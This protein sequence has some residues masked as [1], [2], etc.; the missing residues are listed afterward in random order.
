MLKELLISL[1]LCAASALHAANYLTFT[2]E[3]DDS[4]FGIETTSYGDDPDIEIQYSLDGG[5]TWAALPTGTLISLNYKGDKALLKGKK[6]QAYTQGEDNYT[7]FVMTGRIAAS[8]SV[9]SL[10]DGN[11]KNLT[12]K[13]EKC[14]YRLFIDCTSLTKAPELPATQLNNSCY[15]E[16]FRGCSRLKQAPKLPAK[17]LAKNCY[18]G[19]FWKCTSLTQAPEL[20]ATK[21]EQGCYNSMFAKCTSLTHTPHLPA[22]QLAPYCYSYMFYGCTN[23]TQASELPATQLEKRCYE[24]MFTKCTSLTEISVGFTR[25]NSDTH[26]TYG[27]DEWLDNVAPNGKFICPKGLPKEFG[28]DRIPEGWTIIKKR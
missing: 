17:T 14:F 23:L 2:A 24:G 5:K 27:T 10:I 6:T 19:M 20:P 12:I 26:E 21:M 25:W 3:M 4:E 13:G 16:M 15:E 22:T 8:G 11:D 9:M 7:Y 18:K 28:E 1:F